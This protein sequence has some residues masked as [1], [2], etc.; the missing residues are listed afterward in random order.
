MDAGKVIQVAELYKQQFE[1]LASFTPSIRRYIRRDF[2]KAG[3]PPTT[4][5]EIS[6]LIA[7]GEAYPSAP[8]SSVPARSFD[9]AG[10]APTEKEVWAHC[11]AMVPAIK[12]MLAED[13]L[14]KCC[15]WIG[16]ISGA[17]VATFAFHPLYGLGKEMAV[18]ASLDAIKAAKNG[19][20]LESFCHLGFAQ[21]A[22]WV[23]G[24]Y[25]I[26]E[27]KEHNRPS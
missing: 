27:L 8:G 6:A 3:P 25:S 13:R 21:G 11:E 16:F 19:R 1:A 12:Q 5:D 14:E 15:R 9:H 26:D 2:K 18:C 24:A 10:R 22:L 23:A 17:E 20:L 7:L 4:K